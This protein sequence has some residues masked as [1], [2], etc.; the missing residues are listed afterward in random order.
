MHRQVAS[1]VVVVF[2]AVVGASPV[3]RDNWL[4]VRDWSIVFCFIGLMST[5]AVALVIFYV[6]V[7]RPRIGREKEESI[8]V[9][10]GVG[11]RR[12][13]N[14]S[15][16]T[17]AVPPH[18]NPAPATTTTTTAETDMALP[19]HTFTLPRGFRLY[20]H[21]VAGHSGRAQAQDVHYAAEHALLVE[22]ATGHLFKPLQSN[23]RGDAELV[24]EVC[25]KD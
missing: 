2:A 23:G 18:C 24:G 22:E 6:F 4:T 9:E 19:A 20:D 8:D 13:I 5:V 25:E 17:A 3:V 14:S 21:S 7:Y 1:L 16:N 15:Y 11:G 10:H 12:L